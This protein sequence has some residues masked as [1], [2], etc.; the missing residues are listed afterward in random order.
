MG[1]GIEKYCDNK[2]KPNKDERRFLNNAARVVRVE[3]NKSLRNL[4]KDHMETSFENRTMDS[5]AHRRVLSDGLYEN[6]NI[7]KF[8]KDC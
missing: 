5:F 1:N 6:F 4:M 8:I 3:R 2:Y 7:N